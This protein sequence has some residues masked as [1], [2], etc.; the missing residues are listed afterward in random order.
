MPLP[1]GGNYAFEA[2]VF[3]NPAELAPYLFAGCDKRW[4]IASTAGLNLA[5]YR[6]TRD[7][8]RHIDNLLDAETVAVAEIVIC[9]FAAAFQIVESADMRVGKVGDMNVIAHA[10]AVGGRIILTV[11]ADMS[12]RAVCYLQNYGDKMGFGVVRFADFAAD[13]SSR[14][15]EIAQS[16]VFKPVR[17]VI[18]MHKLLH[19]MLRLTVYARGILRAVLRNQT[20]SAIAVR[21]GGGG[22]DEISDLL[23]YH[24]VKQRKCA[25]DVVMIILGGIDHTLAYKG[26]SRKMYYG[27]HTVLCE[28]L[29]KKFDV[30]NISLDKGHAFGNGFDMTRRQIVVYYNVNAALFKLS[31]AVGTYISRSACNQNHNI[32]LARLLTRSRAIK[33]PMK[34][35]ILKPVVLQDKFVYNQCVDKTILHCDLNNFYASVEQKLHPEYDGLPLAVCGNPQMRHGIVL[36]KNMLAKQA[37]VQTG[38]AIWIS[39]QKCPQIVFVAPHYDE[40]VRISKQVFDIYTSYTDRVESFGIDECWLDV[41]GSENLFGDGKTIADTL[42]E[43]IKRETGLTISVGVSFTKTLAKLGSDLKK[44]DATTVLSK[45]NY[46]SVIGKLSPSELIMIGKRTA[47][48]LENLNIHTIEQLADADRNMLRYHFGIIGDSMVNAA[49]GIETGEVKKYY[50]KQIPKSISNGTTTPRDIENEDEAKIVVY[51]LSELVATRLRQYNLIAVGVNLSIKDPQL[52]WMSKQTTLTTPTSNA[53][54]IALTAMSLLLKMHRFDQPLRAIT[55]GTHKLCDKTEVQMSL[56]DDPDDKE[57]K[58]EQSIDKIRG[59]YG[60]H[61]VKR[62]ILVDEQL[63]GN[64]HEEDDFRPFHQSKNS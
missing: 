48:K 63:T 8:L 60:Y 15:V 20:A 10:G 34:Y 16:D 38:E 62:G 47:H 4:R 21:R 41:T 23:R 64:L 51:A 57:G 17:L 26:I 22:K 35:Y 42:R 6:K 13:V 14:R 32:L 12:A 3:R 1:C 18:F 52:N 9:G 24:R 40:Y 30:E 56:F 54:Q 25:G 28:S 7:L 37:G 43:R 61:S 58:L 46:M 59:K 50:D 33:I 2:V 39:K 45:E 31:Y 44:P 49:L 55:V 53:S 5:F 19:H 29:A 27:I 11:Y 36:A